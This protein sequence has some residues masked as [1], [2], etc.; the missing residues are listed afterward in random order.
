MDRDRDNREITTALIRTGT[1]ISPT[2][3]QETELDDDFAHVMLADNLK[4]LSISKDAGD[5]RFFGKS[6]GAM[7]IQTA[8]ELKQEYTGKQESLRQHLAVGSHRPEFWSLR[9]VRIQT[10][11]T[12]SG[13]LVF[14]H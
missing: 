3:P 7:L 6:S 4:K 1:E 9:P 10:K 11:H 5:Y 13:P 2:H 12:F 8:I 14:I